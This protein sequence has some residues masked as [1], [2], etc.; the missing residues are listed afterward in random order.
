MNHSEVKECRAENQ[1]VSSSIIYTTV[2]ETAVDDESWPLWWMV[3]GS[4]VRSIVHVA[5]GKPS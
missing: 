4:F 2:S 5:Q 3:G 1:F